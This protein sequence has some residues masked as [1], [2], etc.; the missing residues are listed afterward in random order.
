MSEQ[1]EEALRRAQAQRTRI[2]RLRSE[3]VA[4]VVTVEQALAHPALERL[5]VGRVLDW[6]PGYGPHRVDRL[7]GIVKISPVRRCG[8]LT[9]HQRNVIGYVVRR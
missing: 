8:E 1:W 4:G 3:L 7:L 2:R 5:T 6:L 9:E